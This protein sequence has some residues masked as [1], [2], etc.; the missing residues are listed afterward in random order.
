MLDRLRAVALDWDVLTKKHQ[1]TRS[2]LPELRIDWAT[3]YTSMA[4]IAT[5][6][7]AAL[8]QV[9]CDDVTQSA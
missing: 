4:S 9:G 5:A 8:A 3:E 6:Y 2:Q 1:T 7:P